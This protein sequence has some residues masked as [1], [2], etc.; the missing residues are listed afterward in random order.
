MGIIIAKFRKKTSTLDI[1]TK[2]EKDI[3]SIED[4]QKRTQQ[5]QRKIVLRFLLLAI[6]IF[7]A[8]VFLLYIY[9]SQITQDQ[10]LIWTL[11]VVAFPFLMWLIKI[12]LTWYYNRKLRRNENKLLSLKEKKKNILENVKETETYKVAKEILDKFGNEPKMPVLQSPVKENAAPFATTVRREYENVLRQRNLAAMAG[13]TSFGGLP[14]TPLHSRHQLALPAPSTVRATN[15]IRTPGKPLAITSATP[16]TLPRS[17]L[18]RDRSVLDKVVEYLV[19]DGPSN[20]YA[21]IC[22]NCSNHN[23]MALKEEFE[24]LAFTCCYCKAFNPARKKRPVGP[25]FDSSLMLKPAKTVSN[26]A[27]SSNSERNSDQDSDT[28]SEPIVEEPRSDSPDTAKTSDYEKI[29]DSELHNDD[30]KMDVE[31][32]DNPFPTA[33][34]TNCTE[35]KDAVDVVTDISDN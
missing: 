9:F 34:T 4:F 5:T 3:V 11:P 12:F 27:E 33:K 29:S 21:L 7:I 14:G 6:L 23:G 13:R 28:D 10:K 8:L 15:V 2:L 20:R 16:P 18:S 26:D 35:S 30:S 19:G 1:L 31:S 25:K 22:A 32:P 17:I 24:Y